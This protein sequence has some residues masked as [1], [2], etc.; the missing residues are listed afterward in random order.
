MT[1]DFLY[2]YRLTHSE[3]DLRF[4]DDM[5]HQVLNDIQDKVLRMGGQE[6]AT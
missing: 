4:T 5:Y 2:H 3:S 6:L 1:E